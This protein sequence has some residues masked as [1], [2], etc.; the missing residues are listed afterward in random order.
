[1]SVSSAAQLGAAPDGRLWRAA[2]VVAG[3][4]LGSIG[5]AGLVAWAAG[6][7]EYVQIDSRFI[8]LHYNAAIGMIFWGFG[9]IALERHWHRAARLAGV[10][11]L[12]FA[13]LLLVSH[14]SRSGF[15]LDHW[16]FPLPQNGSEFP[17]AGTRP[18][19]I[20]GLGFAATA[21]LL[22]AR[23]EPS[24]VHLLYTALIGLILAI[25]TPMSL[26]AA[27]GM[28][29]HAYAPAILSVIASTT[30]GLA[31]LSTLVRRGMPQVALGSMWPV[32][33]G[34]VGVACTFAI[35][36]ALGT[37]QSQRVQ[38]AVQFE[39]AHVQRVA[40][41]RLQQTALEIADLA[42][43]FT[44]NDPAK[45]KD[46]IGSYIGMH[47]GC[48]GMAR[49]DPKHRL[50]WIEYRASVPPS[51][52]LEELGLS[53]CLSEPIA[54]ARPAAVR[55]PRSAWNGSRML[56][57]Y[58]PTADKGG[59]LAVFRIQDFFSAAVNLN[60]APG[61]CVAIQEHSE[62][63][64]GRNASDDDYRTGW[65]ESLPVRYESFD[66]RLAVWPSREVM[67]RENQPLPQLALAIGLF[68]TGLL[69]LAVH[70]ARTARRRAAELEREV[71]ER[72]QTQHALKQSEA[73]YRS[74]IENLGQGIFLLDREFRY[75]AANATFCRSLGRREDEV[76]GRTE[77]DLF[78]PSRAERHREEARTVIAEGK[79]VESE[80][81]REIEGRKKHI[82]RVLSPVRNE[83]G[84]IAGVLGVCWDVTEQ[85]QL[86]A[87]VHQASKMDAIGQ[88]A[89]GIAH[90][91]NNL[92]TAI[93]GNLD[94]I[95]TEESTPGA[96]LELA[97]AAHNAA[98]RAASLTQRL[99]G[100]SRR[101]KLDW[102]AAD[103]NTI[104]GEV[105][106]L[107]RRTIDPL[108]RIET[109]LSPNL[110]HVQADP[111]QLN[112]VLMN[113]CL[114]ARD[115]MPEGGTIVIET[116][117]IPSA[118]LPPLNGVK[119][120]AGD[121]VRLRVIDSG[122][123]MTDEVKA[124]I[125][126]PF[127]TTKEVGKGTGLGL[128]MVFAI[129]R[130]H[131]GWID[132]WSEVGRGT[133]FDIYLPKSSV[134]RSDTP[135]AQTPGRRRTGKETILVVDDEEMIRRIAVL[136]LRNSGYNVLE[137]ADGQQAVDLF[138]RDGDR[139]DL[140]VLDLT[141]PVLSGHEAF[142]HMLQL[143]PRAR[144]VFA[145]GYAEEQLSDLEKERMRGFL[146][147][148]YRPNDL[149]IAVEAALLGTKQGSRSIARPA[150]RAEVAAFV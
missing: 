18:P 123:G 24:P 120:C 68:T 109:R 90:D 148:P 17:H 101:H 33:I 84:E 99:L 93:I 56:V 139:I 29:T 46:D 62:P 5:L 83:A 95:L 131:K 34:A 104:V 122:I 111:A 125:Y 65:E 37:D 133:R 141:M 10:V 19:L 9:L 114:N 2:H 41:E 59:L 50:T 94:L 30:A 12:A 136:T 126:E 81:E 102:V 110:W 137:A 145:S 77:F 67:Q 4:V 74:L 140:V 15:G 113:L 21:I 130:Q 54:A 75:L 144:V 36:T 11:L 108:I 42:E 129:V 28:Q 85:R 40:N 97:A 88:L 27:W 146:K 149:V 26:V 107:L 121:C 35:C 31:M 1:M 22:A 105:V 100:F 87:H 138:S 119:N 91:F 45:M 55:P 51:D 142:R 25:G 57:L 20:F 89:G 47:P 71:R 82:R 147:K 61:Y 39:A 32:G 7:V 96:T 38:R 73:K 16:L 98:S 72:E 135:N 134:E 53:S 76:I 70:L 49:I 66:W 3:A 132:C 13:G 44:R 112:Q 64:F 60:I 150:P 58:R 63:L 92:L 143:N 128:P 23:N 6:R 116:A 48:I 79:T 115:A 43:R 124:R 106:A 69:A 78:D 52:S 118:E 86:E 80:E 117:C 127:F 14:L 103:A 8:P